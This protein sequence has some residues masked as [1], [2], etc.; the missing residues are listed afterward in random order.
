MA[1]SCRENPKK[2]RKQ[3]YVSHNPPQ[4]VNSV[5]YRREL[6]DIVPR[7]RGAAMSP[8][9]KRRLAF[10]SLL[11]IVLFFLV[12]TCIPTYL[13]IL[14]FFVLICVVC[15]YKAEEFQLFERFGLNPHRGLTVPPALRRWLPGRTFTGVPATRRNKTRT[16]KGDVRNSFA[17]PNDRS[18]VGSVY[19]RDA[20]FSDSVFS[21]RNI[22]MGSYLGKAESPSG[23]GRPAG[24]SGFGRNPREQ[25]RERLVRPN[26]GVSTPNRRLSFG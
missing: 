13:Y 24:G 23:T 10:I 6:W 11:A 22:L 17:S 8:V 2:K 9:D 18:F 12:L 4:A 7:R 26:H 5:R 25:L 21:P 3:N 1:T 19:K 20:T 14:F 16:D 15:Y